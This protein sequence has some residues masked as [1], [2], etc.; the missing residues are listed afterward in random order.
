MHYLS[1]VQTFHLKPLMT[2]VT[3][4]F[5]NKLLFFFFLSCPRSAFYTDLATIYTQSDVDSWNLKGYHAWIGLYRNRPGLYWLWTDGR[6]DDQVF[7]AVNE[8][9][10]DESCA[11]VIYN[12]KR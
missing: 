10:A 8:P 6:I 9:L 7:W 12:S 4:H 3:Y 2:I 5:A 1:N 11:Y